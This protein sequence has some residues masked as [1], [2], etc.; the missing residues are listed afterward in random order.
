MIFH[1]VTTEIDNLSEQVD[2]VVDSIIKSNLKY[3]VI[4]PNNDMGSDK[5]F[6]SYDRFTYMTNIKVFESIDHYDF[7]TLLKNA[8]FIIGNS[9]CGIL[10]APC[11]GKPAVNIG[12][13]QYGRSR[14]RRILN[15]DCNEKDIL[16]NIEWANRTVFDPNGD[17][18][19]HCAD[20]FIEVL[21][22]DGFWGIGKQKKFNLCT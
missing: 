12:S 2:I 4:C 3:I 20:R 14:D 16:K 8:R 11:Y 19:G 5:I 17:A 10:E 22:K 6:K 15:C 21:S 18:D 7:L 9:S 1:P 13:R